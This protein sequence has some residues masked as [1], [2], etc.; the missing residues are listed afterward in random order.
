MNINLEYAENISEHTVNSMADSAYKKAWDG[1]GTYIT[2]NTLT[3]RQ[4]FN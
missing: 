3:L 2:T 4:G 1:L